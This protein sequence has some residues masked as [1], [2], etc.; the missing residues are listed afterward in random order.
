MIAFDIAV[1]ICSELIQWIG[2]S[3]EETNG[4][5]KMVPTAPG[6]KAGLINLVLIALYGGCK[7]LELK[8]QG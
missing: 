6:R 7:L 5:Q 4:I 8:V 1:K 2:I 3:D